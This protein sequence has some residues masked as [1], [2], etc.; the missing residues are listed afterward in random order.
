MK[1]IEKIVFNFPELMAEDA[2]DKIRNLINRQQDLEEQLQEA[3]QTVRTL[4]EY[5]RDINTN[6]FKFSGICTI[7]YEEPKAAPKQFD[8]C[9]MV[10]INPED[11]RNS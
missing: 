8:S 7:V 2:E 10:I 11:A 6:V 3:R 9:N 1:K 4:E 5:L